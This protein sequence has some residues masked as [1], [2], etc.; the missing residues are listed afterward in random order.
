M[1]AP[2]L[3]ICEKTSRWATALR[4]ALSDNPVQIAEA[5]SIALCELALA[6]SPTSLVAIEITTANLSAVLELVSRIRIEFSQARIVALLAPELAPAEAIFREF[7]AIDVATW[8]HEAERIA[9][10]V[11]VYVD[12]APRENLSMSELIAE[13]MPWKAYAA[14]L[15]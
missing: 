13:R 1:S 12:S 14:N 3:I 4:R 9:R 11:R 15:S 7:G 8:T 6:E 2:R 5:R 10:L